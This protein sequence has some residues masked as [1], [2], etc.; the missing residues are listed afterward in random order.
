MLMACVSTIP[1]QQPKRTIPESLL[2][3]CADQARA[4]DGKLSTILR[5][6][7]ERSEQYEECKAKHKALADYTRNEK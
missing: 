1:T 3:A 2:T 7:I 4:K 5:T 6:S